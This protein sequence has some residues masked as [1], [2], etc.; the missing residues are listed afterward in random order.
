MSKLEECTKNETKMRKD[1]FEKRNII[2]V[3]S[4]KYPCRDKSKIYNNGEK[5]REGSRTG[6]WYQYYFRHQYIDPLL[7]L[8]D[9]FLTQVCL[10]IYI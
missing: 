8:S 9:F 4:G 6:S 1:K 7:D 10:I 3:M 5:K 2:D